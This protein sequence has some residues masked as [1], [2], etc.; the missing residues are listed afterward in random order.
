MTRTCSVCEK[1]GNAMEGKEGYTGMVFTGQGTV[2]AEIKMVMRIY[3]IARVASAA[4]TLCY[5][6]LI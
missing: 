5:S 1:E 6:C 4:F 3:G 2:G